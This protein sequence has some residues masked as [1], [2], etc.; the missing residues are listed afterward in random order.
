MRP[1]LHRLAGLT[2]LAAAL[3]AGCGG[4]TASAPDD[5][6]GLQDD[7]ASS[8]CRF[9]RLE[10]GSTQ[11]YECV[12][13]QF[14]AWIDNDEARWDFVIAPAHETFGDVRIEADV[15]FE[16]GDD[17]GA[18]FTCRGTPLTGDYY[19]FRL[20]VEGAEI[21]DVLEGEEQ[22]SRGFPLPEGAVRQDWNHLRADCLG[23]T[24]ALYLNGELVLERQ[25]ENPYPA[26]DIGLGAGG[27]SEGFS[28]VRFDNLQVSEP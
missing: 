23:D 5:S 25:M 17:A 18:Y 19:Y 11:G 20:S 2:L 26:G 21:T 3:L 16:S 7:F 6:P 15:R 10:A 24:L 14:R 12:D 13:G 1:Q 8:D 22:V 4:E 9:G 28:A 27:G